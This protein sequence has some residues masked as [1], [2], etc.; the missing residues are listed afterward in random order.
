ML[1]A[2]EWYPPKQYNPPD[3]YNCHNTLREAEE[4]TIQRTL[5]HVRDI[6]EENTAGSEWYHGKGYRLIPRELLISLN[7]ACEE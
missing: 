5:C 2:E 3:I 4:Q 7:E 6:L 1:K